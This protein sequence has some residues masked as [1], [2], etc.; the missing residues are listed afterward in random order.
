M[1]IYRFFILFA[2]AA[3]LLTSSC[4]RSL[5]GEGPLTST[6]VKIEDFT[7]LTV[8]IP[9]NVKLVISDSLNC[10]IHAQKNIADAIQLKVRGNELTIESEYSLKS[11]DPIELFISVPVMEEVQVNGSG[12]VT[13]INRVKG[14]KIKF[15]VNGSGNINAK[16]E[17]EEVKGELNGSGSLTLTGAAT[18]ASYNINGSG[19]LNADDFSTDQTAIEINGSGDAELNV[20]S[21]LKADIRGSGNIKYK[22]QPHVVS[23]IIGSGNIK[24]AE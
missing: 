24:K 14:E 16:A 7:S 8:D 17:V 9:V 12:D 5:R 11:N 20:T 2:A 21:K 19:D 18:K 13:F 6:P 15:N 1:S 22:G 23:E 10:I 3:L 4:K